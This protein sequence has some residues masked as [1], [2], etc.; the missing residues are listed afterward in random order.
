LSDAKRLAVLLSGSGTTLENLF[1][2]VERGELPV[3]IAVVVSSRRDAYGIERAKRRGVPTHVI[4]RKRYESLAEYTDAVFAKVREA[5]AGLVALAG[6]MVQIGVPEDFRGKIL[7]VHPALLPAFGGKGMYGHFVHEAVLA[8]GCR[9][10]GCTVHVVD[11]EY[12]HGPI[13]M[14]KAV[15]VRDDD[16]PDT[17]AERVQAAEREVY[18]AAIRAFAEGRAGVEGRWVT[19]A[20]E[21]RS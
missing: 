21:G 5:G 19:L 18:P 7:N 3:E 15:E 11:D 8:H 9:V 2:H 6:F 10:T 17:L 20:R 14:Q 4:P 16:T 12:D 1:E 13:V